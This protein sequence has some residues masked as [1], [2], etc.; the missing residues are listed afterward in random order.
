MEQWHRQLDFRLGDICWRRS[1]EL[2][3]LFRNTRTSAY[4]GTMRESAARS[5]TRLYEQRAK[6][7][8]ELRANYERELTRELRDAPLAT[9][10]S[11]SF[12][13]PNLSQACTEPPGCCVPI[14]KGGGIAHEEQTMLYRSS[15]P[16]CRPLGNV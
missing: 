11:D 10:T 14:R 15:G 16:R 13:N 5:R 8:R 9:R 1:S 4:L 6:T 3:V 7:T 12:S 2:V